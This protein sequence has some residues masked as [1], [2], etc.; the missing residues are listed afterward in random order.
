MGD[1]GS[2]DVT[3]KQPTPNACLSGLSTRMGPLSW[4]MINVRRTS[5]L[6]FSRILPRKTDSVHHYQRNHW[7]KS[8]LNV[9]GNC[10]FLNL[11]NCCWL[12]FWPQLCLFFSSFFSTYNLNFWLTC[13]R[14]PSFSKWFSLALVSDRP[15]WLAFL[16]E[17]LWVMILF[18]DVRTYSTNA[19]LF[20]AFFFCQDF[21]PYVLTFLGCI[22]K[23]QFFFCNR[24]SGEK[25]Y[26]V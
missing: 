10:L 14:G 8:S 5:W 15:C 19:E 26:C 21:I 6:A 7:S 18:L 25:D 13:S 12:A 4:Y 3:K 16:S 1:P 17:F 23:Q 22:P 9:M 2:C 20:W 24:I 11:G